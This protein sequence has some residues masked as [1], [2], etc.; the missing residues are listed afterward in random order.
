MIDYAATFAAFF[1]M[2][3][4]IGTAPVLLVVT[5]DQDVPTKR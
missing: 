2:I 1:A 5:R 4:P 3:N